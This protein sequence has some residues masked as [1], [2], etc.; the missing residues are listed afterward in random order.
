MGGENAALQKKDSGAKGKPPPM[1]TGDEVKLVD[2]QLQQASEAADKAQ[3]GD[4]AAAKLAVTLMR[5]ALAAHGD[6]SIASKSLKVTM[7]GAFMKFG[8]LYN[9]LKAHPNKDAAAYAPEVLSS[10]H[11]M[12]TTFGQ[13]GWTLPASLDQI[14][15]LG[16][17]AEKAGA[18]K[19]TP[20]E[21]LALGSLHVRA[22][23]EVIV[24]NWEALAAGDLSSLASANVSLAAAT[25]ILI[26]PI[27]LDQIEKANPDI[28][29]F[30]QVFARLVMTFEEQ[31]A[32]LKAMHALAHNIDALV[33]LLERPPTWSAKVGAT[34]TESKDDKAPAK[35]APTTN[36]TDPGPT[37]AEPG[38]HRIVERR[39]WT[40]KVYLMDY[41]YFDEYLGY[42]ELYMEAFKTASGQVYVQMAKATKKFEGRAGEYLSMGADVSAHS[43]NENG[44]KS[45]DVYFNIQIGGPGKTETSGVEVGA[46]VGVSKGD[47]KNSNGA[48]ASANVTFSTAITSQG[49]RAF[50]RV[51]RITSLGQKVDQ[52]EMHD[53]ANPSP[54]MVSSAM[55]FGQRTDLK[56]DFEDFELDDDDVGDTVTTFYANWKIDS[57]GGD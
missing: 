50:R 51:Y 20:E 38:M 37:R 33:R 9:T 3:T 11:Q 43:V 8:D 44:T 16:G 45:A 17:A 29:A 15:S 47:G 57:F 46:K 56:Q 12:K 55:L 36:E 54:T 10:L 26:N 21:K 24:G 28:T 40:K 49:T 23:R 2:L 32:K 42:V 39:N 53:V 34:K 19:M 22:A 1:T 6:R 25:G 52:V 7:N 41:N 5:S 30:E 27:L 48:E 18:T 4:V 14:H 13:D 35:D 31:P